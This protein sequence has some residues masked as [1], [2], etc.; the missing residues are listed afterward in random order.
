MCVSLS[1]TF[2]IMFS[3]MED[4]FL[5]LAF[6]KMCLCAN[7]KFFLVI[8]VLHFNAGLP[9]LGYLCNYARVQKTLRCQLNIYGQ[10]AKLE[11]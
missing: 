9:V 10:T 8:M 5:D 11:H 7:M 4:I 3:C 2:S 6:S 1:H